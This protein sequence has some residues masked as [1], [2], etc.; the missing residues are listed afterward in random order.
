MTQ[1]QIALRSIGCSMGLGFGWG[2]L[3]AAA[4]VADLDDSW[5]MLEFLG[6]L[7]LLAFYGGGIGA[8]VGFVVGVPTVFLIHPL[9]ADLPR[10]RRVG[11]VVAAGL[12]GCLTAG[13]ALIDGGSDALLLGGPVT[14]AA[15]LSAWFGLGWIF[16]PAAHHAS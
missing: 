4:S 15:A 8:V 2:T 7:P 5:S 14:I 13:L 3:A 6:L 1:R 10:C 12:P 9:R 11:A 16:R